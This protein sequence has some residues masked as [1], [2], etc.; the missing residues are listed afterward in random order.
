MYR[1]L[2]YLVFWPVAALLAAS[3]GNGGEAPAGGNAVYYWRT[4]FAA[5][6]AERAF[7]ARH[8]V[9]KIY[10]RFFD[11]YTDGLGSQALPQATVVFKDTVPAGTKVVPVVYITDRAMR[12]MQS[13]TKGYA[14]R[15]LRRVRAICM[16]NKI[17]FDELQL[18]CDWTRTTRAPFFGLCRAIKL[19]LDTSQTLS[20]TV[21]LHQLTQPAPPVD[22]GVLMVYN[23]GNLMQVTTEN[24][25]FSYDDIAPYLRGNRLARYT[26]P[27]DVA[28]PAYGWSVVFSERDG[29]YKFDR[30]M[31]RTDF[32][33][34]DGIVKTG[35]GTYRVTGMTY[36]PPAGQHGENGEEYGDYL[37]G[38]SIIKTERPDA[39]QIVA[40]KALIERQLRGKPHATV[41]YHLDSAQ[42]S[43]YTDTQID[44]IYKAQ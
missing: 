22:K 42:L 19:Q 10:M 4:V 3:C 21:R 38:G 14:D 25:I 32:S 40:V 13:D 44:K 36:V 37:Y 34:I 16:Q 30:L 27:L 8:G 29:T 12:A 9:G 26:L 31:R 2:F 7:L 6:P 28:Y 24:S 23:T 18:D 5:D 43:H 41:I 33:G 17:G 1:K 11:V 35:D 20:S 39:E 15:I